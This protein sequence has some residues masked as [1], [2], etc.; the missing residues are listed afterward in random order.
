MAQ[1]GPPSFRAGRVQVRVPA[2]SANLGPGFDALGLALG[3]YNVVAVRV[4]D[5]GLLVDVAGEGAESVRRDNRNLVVRA[6][7]VAF[8][9]LG[10]QPRGLEVVCVNRIPHGRGLGSSAAAIV[11]GVCA[12]RAAVLGGMT[13]EDVLRI[14]TEIEGHP[15]NVAACLYGGATLAWMAPNGVRAAPLDVDAAISPVVFVPG[16]T[17]QSTKAARSALPAEVSHRDAALTAG[18]A[19]LLVRALAGRPDLLFDATEDRLH[20]PYR[21]GNQPRGAALVER[22]R[23]AGIAAVLSGSGPSVLALT[24]SPRQR[25]L[26]VSLT[27]RDFA[28]MAMPVDREGAIEQPAT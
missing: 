24:T 14:A 1:T 4:V 23:A 13:D 19:A 2:T 22:L 8:D 21:L 12:A 5:S 17:R 25:D 26:A 28:A 6:M 3:L 9:E 20:Q 15:D 16:G 27:G 10:G 7:R 18:R 11:S